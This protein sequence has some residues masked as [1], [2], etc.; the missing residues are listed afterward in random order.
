MSQRVSGHCI[1]NCK[2]T[3]LQKNE[4]S[5]KV[6]L[7]DQIRHCMRRRHCS[8]RTEKS[9]IKWIKRYIYFHKKQHPE[10][11]N[12][13]HITE[14]LYYLA[15]EK[16]VA[17]STQNAEVRSSHGSHRNIKQLQQLTSFQVC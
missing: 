10:D 14:F 7:L 15:V 11:L 1:D 17:S 2:S 5:H 16:K 6:R 4:N 8:I 3:F 9:Y 13:N 12:E